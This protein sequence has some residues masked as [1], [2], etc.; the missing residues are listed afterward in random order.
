[1]I[2]VA[3]KRR[4][5]LVN[6]LKT[7]MLMNV[8]DLCVRLNASPAT[9]RRELIE[10]EKLGLIKRVSGGACFRYREIRLAANMRA[11]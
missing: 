7:N 9:I 5:E 8:Q 10:L 4:Q 6:L 2:V 11:S 1:M 3:K